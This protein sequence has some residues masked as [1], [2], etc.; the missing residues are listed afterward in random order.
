MLVQNI[1]WGALEAI[2]FYHE[3]YQQTYQHNVYHTWLA[4][5]EKFSTKN[6][7]YL[8]QS[9]KINYLGQAYNITFLRNTTELITYDFI[10]I[11]NFHIFQN[12]FDW[13]TEEMDFQGLLFYLLTSLHHIKPNGSMLIRLNM[14]CRKSWYIIFDIIQRFFKEYTFIRPTTCNPFNSEIYLSLDKFYLNGILE[15]NVEYGT[16][17]NLYASKAYE[18]FYVSA[19]INNDSNI[20]YQKY[21]LAVKKWITNLELTLESLNTKKILEN[22]DVDEWHKSNDLKQIKNMTNE[23]ENKS[24]VY[25]LKTFAPSFVLKPTIPTV[26][27]QK[28]FYTKLIQKRADLNYY[29]RIMDT[30]PSEIFCDNCYKNNDNYLVTWE[31]LSNQID[32]HSGLKYILHDQFQAEMVTNAWIKMYEMLNIFPEIIPNNKRIKSFHL[33]EAPGAFVADLIIICMERIKN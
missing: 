6:I 10:S 1:N 23:F 5:N 14:I 25:V 27:Y 20:I 31:Q 18:I 15:T 21:L 13:T 7:G 8:L 24:T 30:K 22:N 12:I 2:I 29:K 32:F 9:P 26:L 4:N 3:K 16:L 17:K 33:C 11:D 19:K 28:Q